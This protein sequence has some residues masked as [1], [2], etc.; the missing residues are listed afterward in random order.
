VS[1][2]CQPYL[3]GT[4]SFIVAIASDGTNIVWTDSG[5]HSILE[6]P[7]AGGAQI[8]LGTNNAF[9]LL[10]GI[11][12]A[13]GQVPFLVG[14][15][16]PTLWTAT[17]GVASSAVQAST[18]TSG[19]PLQGFAT[20]GGYEFIVS[21]SASMFDVY[22][23]SS[24]TSCSIAKTV[25]GKAGLQMA[26]N[27]GT[28][29]WTINSGSVP[30]DGVYFATTGAPSSVS[31]VAGY[32]ASVNVAA[33]STYV[34]WTAG[35]AIYQALQEA[36]APGQKQLASQIPGT[37]TGLATDGT[38]VY[39]TNYVSSALGS[40]V[41]EITISAG[42]TGTGAIKQIVTTSDILGQIIYVNGAIAW[43]DQT[44]NTIHALSLQ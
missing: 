6:V 44:T 37:V 23:C 39:F 31:E 22:Y 7:F 2:V 17:E 29:F 27:G 36:G 5:A 21:P 11:G 38:K 8:A 34:Y 42:G 4:G 24:S 25:T 15:S 30:P 43:I 10:G 12:I 32:Q 16:P 9:T 33:D 41:G 26:A 19:T 13:G 14:G 3:A 35:T 20:G 18:L 28:F 1:S 40:Y